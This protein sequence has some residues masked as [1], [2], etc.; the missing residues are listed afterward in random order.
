M[1]DFPVWQGP[2]RDG[3]TYSM[4]SKFIHC[5]ERFR[6]LTILGLRPVQEFNH[7]LEYGNMWHVCELAVSEGND[8]KPALL[9]YG[10]QLCQKYP[11]TQP[12]IEH[13]YTICQIQFEIY[14]KRYPKHNQGTTI[15]S[16]ETVDLM[17]R[18][19]SRRKVR[20][21]GKVDRVYEEDS[22]LYLQENKTKGDIDVLGVASNLQF[23]LQTMM[24]LTILRKM[25]LDVNWV[26]YNVVRRPLSGGKYTIR[27]NKGETTQEFYQRLRQLI[28]QDQEWFFMR[29]YVKLQQYDL[30]RF[31]QTCFNPLLG[32][33][34]NW[35]KWVV[36]HQD[37]PFV[38]GN[39]VHWRTPYGVYNPT[40]EGRSSELDKYLETGSM[41]G[42]ET[43]NNLFQ[44]LS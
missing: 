26:T 44:E 28:E 27:V 43:T 18:L 10:K 30:D 39:R 16:E 19:P 8:W 32:D 4:L 12:T 7:R 40:L 13:W 29:W 1:V 41:V 22:T 35:W 17:Y 20:L 2:E 3:I 42:L 24:Y 5:R 34:L 21:R 6:L 36:K 15:L 37:D 38:R 9:N 31:V 11:T 33:L 14:L 23:D 25:G